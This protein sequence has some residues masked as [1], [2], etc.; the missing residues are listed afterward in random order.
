MG[1]KISAVVIYY[2]TKKEIEKDPDTKGVS[3][4]LERVESVGIWQGKEVFN[5]EKCP[6]GILT[7]VANYFKKMKRPSPMTLTWRPPQGEKMYFHKIKNRTMSMRVM[8]NKN[9]DSASWAL[10]FL[11]V[12]ITRIRDSKQIQRIDASFKD[13]NVWPEI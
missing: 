3:N 11:E 1:Y 2:K 6:D 7:D 13:F 12:S 4:L 10:Q 5:A 9:D 8:I